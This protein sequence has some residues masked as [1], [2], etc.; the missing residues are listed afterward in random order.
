LD[1][2]LT[3][4]VLIR[5]PAKRAKRECLVFDRFLTGSNLR[6]LF[7]SKHFRRDLCRIFDRPSVYMNQTQR[8][9]VKNPNPHPMLASPFHLAPSAFAKFTTFCGTVPRKDAKTPRLD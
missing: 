8:T 9:P 5:D 6:K 7:V 1:F 3:P 2:P 4:F